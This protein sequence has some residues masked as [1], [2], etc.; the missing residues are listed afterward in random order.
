MGPLSF[1]TAGC[2]SQTFYSFR[3]RR[4]YSAYMEIPL[5][6]TMVGERAGVLMLRDPR[7]PMDLLG[8]GPWN[9]ASR[10]SSKWFSWPKVESLLTAK[11]ASVNG[12]MDS[13]G[14]IF[15]GAVW[16]S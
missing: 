13:E 3:A 11:T 4:G 6:V 12:V 8:G 15:R 16:I 7:M 14:V 5:S 9:S 10:K 1:R 2:C